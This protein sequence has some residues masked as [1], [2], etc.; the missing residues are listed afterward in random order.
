[1]NSFSLC[2]AIWRI[3]VPALK[4]CG[5]EV[6]WLSITAVLCFYVKLQPLL[7]LYSALHTV[8]HGFIVNVFNTVVTERNN[9]GN[10]LSVECL[11]RN[12]V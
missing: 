6:Q 10:H 2:S 12:E 3:C 8:D 4:S 5:P 11:I 7:A 9:P 1:M